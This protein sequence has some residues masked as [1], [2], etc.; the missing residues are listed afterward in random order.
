MGKLAFGSLREK[1]AALAEDRREAV[2]RALTSEAKWS[3]SEPKASFSLSER[4]RAF[5]SASASELS[6]QRGRRPS[7]SLHA[8][9][10]SV[11][12]FPLMTE[13]TLIVRFPNR[14]EWGLGLLIE[15]RD[16]KRYY[17]FEDGERH[18]LLELG[19]TKLESVALPEKER[20]ALERKLKSLAN[21]KEAT[22]KKAKKRGASRPAAS[23]SDQLALFATKFP[24]GFLGDKY[25][26]DERA[27]A[28]HRGPRGYKE[29]IVQMARTGLGKADLDALR[30]AG[31]FSGVIDKLKKVMQ[32]AFTLMHP[33]SDVVPFTNMA[34]ANH[35][36]FVDTLIDLLHGDGDYGKRFDRYVEVLARGK[37]TWPLATFVPAVLR[38]NEHLF[39]KPQAIEEQAQ[40]LGQSLVYDPEPSG[41]GYARMRAI[42]EEIRRRL[43]EAGQQPRDLLDVYTFI[44]L[45]RNA[46]SASGSA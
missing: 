17:D 3:L 31:D 33:Q 2:G 30:S 20:A 14:P 18:V 22:A 11:I 26:E 35:A 36:A 27:P 42:G 39:V 29:R 46:P 16:G 32:S 15:E 45:T 6:P 43:I 25:V 5:P 23:F 12:G 13:P 4:Q 21:R 38:P 7:F 8:S 10:A 24:G 28:D 37:V 40:V 34:P 41:D 1:L 44:W 19:W 9:A